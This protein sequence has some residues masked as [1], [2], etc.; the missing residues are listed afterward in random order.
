[1]KY[2]KNMGLLLMTMRKIM[3]KGTDLKSSK[4][5]MMIQI[6]LHKSNLSQELLICKHKYF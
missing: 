4:L 5:E 1:M 6:Y 2:L 3:E